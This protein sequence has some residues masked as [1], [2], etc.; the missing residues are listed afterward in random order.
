VVI[1][2]QMELGKITEERPGRWHSAKRVLYLMERQERE[3]PRARLRVLA[4]RVLLPALIV[5][6]PVAFPHVR[7]LRGRCQE[8]GHQN[9]PNEHEADCEGAK[10]DQHSI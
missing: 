8:P 4:P 5:G 1:E 2:H 3:P 9:T 7:T 6:P 10:N